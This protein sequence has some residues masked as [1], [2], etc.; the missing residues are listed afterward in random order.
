MVTWVQRNATRATPGPRPGNVTYRAQQVNFGAP[1]FTGTFTWSRDTVADQQ[2]VVPLDNNV[3]TDVTSIIGCA[4]MTGAGAAL[5][6]AQVRPGNSAV[7]IGAGGVGLS[8]IQACANLSADPIIVVDLTEE[9]LDFSKRFGATVGINARNEDPVARVREL[10]GGELT[11]GVDVAFDAIGSGR[12]MEQILHMARGRQ[13]GER[14]G[15]M[16]GLVR[17]SPRQNPTPPLPHTFLP[18]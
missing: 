14:E 16:A 5:N 9:K 1:A 17:L 11:S 13:P 18:T 15:R 12:T 10:M 8:V 6:A 4:V 2:M 3:A 7:I